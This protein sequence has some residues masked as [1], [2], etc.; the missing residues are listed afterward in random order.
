MRAIRCNSEKTTIRNVTTLSL[1]LL[2]S[3][4]LA[5]CS[6][7]SGSS[8]GGDATSS[9]E[10]VSSGESA[11]SGDTASSSEQ[12]AAFDNWTSSSS[13]SPVSWR[14]TVSQVG[15]FK[16]E[17]GD[18]RASYHLVPFDA[19]GTRV[20]S[21]DG[22]PVMGGAEFDGDRCYVIAG[23]RL[24]Y[25]VAATGDDPNRYGLVTPEGEVLIGCEAATFGG[26]HNARGQLRFLTICYAG[27]QASELSNTTIEVDG[28]DYELRIRVYD[29]VRRT[30]VEGI[31]LNNARCELY[32]LG[33]HFAVLEKSLDSNTDGKVTLYDEEGT[34]VWSYGDAFAKVGPDCIKFSNY[35]HEAIVDT[36]G[37]VTFTAGEGDR[38]T[39]IR[40]EGASGGWPWSS[41]WAYK[42]AGEDSC[43]IIDKYGNQ[44]VEGTYSIV[45]NEADGLFSVGLEDYDHKA[46][47]NMAGDQLDTGSVMLQMVVPGYT[48]LVNDFYHGCKK[49]S[50]KS[51]PNIEVEEDQ[52]LV[53][54][55]GETL[56]FDRADNLDQGLV[57][58]MGAQDANYGA[59]DLFTGQQVL[60]ADYESIQ[61]AGQ[62]AYAG[63]TCYLFAFSRGEWIVFEA[64][65]VQA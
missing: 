1:A 64:R 5:A 14:W 55:T 12:S 41:F 24:V 63:G 29:L 44:V 30:F 61:V 47:I 4:A 59:W 40:C 3:L 52:Y 18:V 10:A 19:A 34:D 65:R 9:A 57:A 56:A 37:N 32:N 31:E 54:T 35:P 60:D 49:I 51:G 23:D 22:N 48:E 6:G 62:S 16:G 21:T 11:Q 33:D 36:S 17:R 42:K 43:V 27:E 46:L 13:E 28:T 50:A 53:L 38:L 45:Y 7:G 26:F 20:L 39:E 58:G 15:S 2:L 8:S 25:A